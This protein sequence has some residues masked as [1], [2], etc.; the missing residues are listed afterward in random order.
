MS[1][2]C[3]LKNIN[4]AFGNKVLFDD[5]SF[6]ISFGDR[7]GL[8]GL[9]GQGKS[10][11]FKILNG[12]VKPDTSTP[13]FTFDKTKGSGDIGKEFSCFL[14][15]QEMPLEENDDVTI[16][17]YIYRFH[18]EVKRLNN[19]L[20][21]INDSFE[22]ELDPD[23]I[24]KLIDQQSEVQEKFE[25]IGGWSI[26]QNYE[27]CLRNFGHHD[28]DRKICDLSGG[29][30]KKVLISLGLSANSNLILWDEP[31]NHL[32]LETIKLFEE[33]LASS[34]KTFVIISHDR[35]L[36]G[37]LT[38]KIFHLQRGKTETFE[39]SYQ[40]Y[41]LYLAHEEQSRL[42]HLNKLQNSLRREQAWM[43]QGIKARGTRSKKRVEGF[44]D[45][46]GS[47]R[48]LKSRA[49]KQ[50]DMTISNTGRKTR[51]LVEFKDVHFG[52]DG[53]MLFE[54]ID[55]TLHKGDKVGLMGSN[56]V[57][58]STLIKLIQDHFT[59]TSGTFKKAD[60]LSIQYFS[61]KREELDPEKTPFDILGDGTDSVHLPNGTRKHV[62]AYFESFLFNRD[63]LHR[64]LKTFSGG[65]KNRL[66]MALNL[67]KAG[68]L[69]I[70]D[71]P[72][73]DLDLETLQILE[74]KLVEFGGSLI[75]ISH[76]RSFLSNVTNKIWLLSNKKMEKFESGYAH[77]EPYL[78]AIA[79]ENIILEQ[80]RSESK[81][82]N[83]EVQTQ[84]VEV[85]TAIEL[86]PLSNKE[87]EQLK[88]LPTKIEEAE[89]Q[90]GVIQK[91]LSTFDF[92]N[93]DEGTKEEYAQFSSKLENLE[94]SLLEMYEE[95]EL[96]EGRV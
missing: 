53:N 71:E 56:G 81:G 17:E 69:W 82:K 23:K 44:H 51:A 3:T 76:D 6:N 66:Q 24:E 60:D 74:D 49:K 38:S 20:N 48:D 91:Y 29:E 80:E 90:A 28:F 22:T 14:V 64:P 70:F 87:K 61:Q 8:L 26:I 31:T 89:K 63:E 54:G 10:S 68:D 96:L 19:L 45:I 50:L 55:F 33:E 67:L 36:L 35:Y 79:L 16:K 86:A 11:L 92:S 94:E 34:N 40:D 13:P 5:A 47:I 95:M 27:S 58:K 25:H 9:N 62:A 18:P 59:I 83:K 65:E 30:Q 78:D 21:K 41:L 42:S 43:N 93:M 77:V 75:L 15:P 72:T 84:K 32:D 73:N 4:L 39:G 85:E 1:I 46:K 2:L 52:F 12:D 7:V 57:G 37:K 88:K